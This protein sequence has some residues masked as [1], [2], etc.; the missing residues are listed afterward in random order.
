V[1]HS[2]LPSLSHPQFPQIFSSAIDHLVARI[3]VKPQLGTCCYETPE[4]RRGACDA[5][6]CRSL[7]TVHHLATEQEFCARH[8]AEVNRG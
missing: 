2:T 1:A 3:A 4:S 7:A 5:T 8:F 6:P